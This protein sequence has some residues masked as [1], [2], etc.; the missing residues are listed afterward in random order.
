[1]ELQDLRRRIYRKAKAD[2]VLSLGLFRRQ[3][4]KFLRRQEG[5]FSRF[6]TLLPEGIQEQGFLKH[7]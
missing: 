2:R 7:L 4:L 5:R 6:G 1:M 3:I